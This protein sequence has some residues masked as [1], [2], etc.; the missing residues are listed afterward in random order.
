MANWSS[1][2]LAFPNAIP[3]RVWR[4]KKTY[5]LAY[6]AGL[7]AAV[8]EQKDPAVREKTD[9]QAATKA[10]KAIA[11]SRRKE[12]AKDILRNVT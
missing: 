10:A 12:N 9:N 6:A 3:N 7:T 4:K 5:R 11:I 2:L 1:S 8:S